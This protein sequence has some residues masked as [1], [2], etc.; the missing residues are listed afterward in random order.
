M[1]GAAAELE[2][3]KRGDMRAFGDLLDRLYPATVRLAALLDDGNA[4]LIA[5]AAW[6][7]LV[8]TED[9]DGAPSLRAWLLCRVL[10]RATAMD[11]RHPEPEP[12]PARF[13]GDD[14]LW[15][16][17][18]IDPVAPWPEAADAGK[19]R[20][21]VE[22]TLRELPQLIA[23]TVVLR[24]VEGFDPEEVEAVIGLDE[25]EQRELLHEGRGAVRDALAGSHEEAA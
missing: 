19:A 4:R 17:G 1:T 6:L 10:E 22:A 9:L 20:A 5:R 2:P 15:A 21:L 8:A 12:P 24:D 14:E 18:W 23:A 13:F 3:L 7:D 16:G 25:D 11:G